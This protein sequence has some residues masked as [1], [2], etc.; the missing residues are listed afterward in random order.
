ME[1]SYNNSYQGSIQIALYGRPCRSLGCWTG[2][3]E[4]PTTGPDLVRDTYEKVDLIWSVSSQL[5][6]RKRVMPID[7]GDL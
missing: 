7:S 3:G 2:V 1:F 6:A 5:K 4:R